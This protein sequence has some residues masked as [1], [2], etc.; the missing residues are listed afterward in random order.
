MVARHGAYFNYSFY[1]LGQGNDPR[2]LPALRAKTFQDSA[3]CA[4]RKV[5]HIVVVTSCFG[6]LLAN[7]WVLLKDPSSGLWRVVIGRLDP[8]YYILPIQILLQVFDFI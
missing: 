2:G 6:S 3:S 1:N 7:V 8:L 4:M 5:F